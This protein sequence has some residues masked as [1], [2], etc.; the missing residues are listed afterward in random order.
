MGIDK[1]EGWFHNEQEEASMFVRRHIAAALYSQRVRTLHKDLSGMGCRT[2]DAHNLM[3]CHKD[4]NKCA[5][6]LAPRDYLEEN[7]IQIHVFHVLLRVLLV[8]FFQVF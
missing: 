7:Q 6:R 3:A 4:E 2:S 1:E 8:L 5:Q